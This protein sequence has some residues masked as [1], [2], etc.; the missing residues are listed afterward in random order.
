MRTV[1]IILDVFVCLTV[2]ALIPVGLGFI[3]RLVVTAVVYGWG[4]AGSGAS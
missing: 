1:K 4:L 2:L 3:A